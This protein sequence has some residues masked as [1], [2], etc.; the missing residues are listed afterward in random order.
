MTVVGVAVAFGSVLY[1]VSKGLSLGL[2]LLVGTALTGLLSPMGL[3]PFAAAL[4]D[5]LKSPM[6][7]QLVLAVALISGLG[8]VMKATGD[9]E[10]MISSL[11]ALFPKPK[12]LVMLLPALVGT[13]NVPGGAIMSA[14]LVEENTR[15]LHLDR[16]SQAAINLFFRHIGYYVYPLHTSMIVLSELMDIPKQ[17]IIKYN[18]LPMLV[19][20]G[21]AYLLFFKRAQLP[22]ADARQ[23]SSLRHLLSFLQSF[24]PIL[25]ILGLMLLLGLPFYLAAAGGLLWALLRNLPGEKRS[26]ALLGRLKELF[27]R[28]IDYKL[29]LTILSLLLFRSVVEASGVTS[30]L[31][32]SFFRYGI[33]LP[34]LVMGLGAVAAYLVGMH[35][36]AAGLLAP[37]FATLFPPCPPGPVHLPA[38]GFHHVRLLALSPPPLSGLDQPVLRHKLWPDRGETGRASAGHRFDGLGSAALPCIAVPRRLQG[39]VK[40]PR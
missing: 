14:P 35:M 21:A 31:A 34:I 5:G 2:A 36:A 30:T 10:E 18:A 24:S 22:P 1:L 11:V 15:A 28:W 8:K 9:L 7:W 26:R 32:A 4:W 13:I 19:G 6:T 3:S 16:T 20:L 40:R 23:E 25:V 39:R 37:F 27:T 38:F 33:P 17:S 12:A 29:A